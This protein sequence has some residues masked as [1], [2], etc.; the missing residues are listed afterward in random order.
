[1]LLFVNRMKRAH[2]RRLRSRPMMSVPSTSS[3][4]PPNQLTGST[5]AKISTP[6][7]AVTRK[8]AEVLISDTF[9]ADGCAV[10]ARVNRPHI[11]AFETRFS[12]KNSPRTAGFTSSSPSCSRVDIACDRDAVRS[13]VVL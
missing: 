9:V 1:M 6:S 2:F 13:A 10:S 12:A 8:L 4:A 5:S 11:T 7:T 3:A